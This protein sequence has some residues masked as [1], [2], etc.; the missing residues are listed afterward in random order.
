[1][2]HASIIGDTKINLNFKEFLFP[3][4]SITDIDSHAAV[5]WPCFQLLLPF[6][7]SSSCHD[8]TRMPLMDAFSDK[9]VVFNGRILEFSAVT[10]S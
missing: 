3:V 4:F 7:L 1:M 2:I 6:H 9:H 8:V 10:I 5:I